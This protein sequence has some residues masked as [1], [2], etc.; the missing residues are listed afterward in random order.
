MK[1]IFAIFLTVVNLNVLH[2]FDPHDAAQLR[3]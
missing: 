1:E 3:T 2:I